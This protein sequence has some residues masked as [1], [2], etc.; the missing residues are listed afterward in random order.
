VSAATAGGNIIIAVRIKP[1]EPGQRDGFEEGRGA[2][3]RDAVD[4]RLR[5]EMTAELGSSTATADAAGGAASS[6]SSSSSRDPSSTSSGRTSTKAFAP[7][8]VFMT[9]AGQAEVY[10]AAAKELVLGVVGGTNAA[11]IAYGQTG[12]GKTHTMLGEWTASAQAGVIPRAIADIFA[13]L[14]ALKRDEGARPGVTGVVA[15][16]RA[17]YVEVYQEQPYD[18]LALSEEAAAAAA[19]GG[20]GARASKPVTEEPRK[21]LRIR[22]DVESD[23]FY[24]EE[25]R[26]VLLTSPEHALEILSAGFGLRRTSSTA[27]NARSS[28][29]HAIL[30]LAVDVKVVARDA[31]GVER[32]T[33]RSGILDIVDLAGSERQRDTGAEGATVKEAGKINNSLGCLAEVIKTTV[34]NQMTKNCR[35]VKPVPWRNSRLTMLLKR[36]LSG[37]SRTAMIFTVSPAVDY[38]AES[39]NTL[40]FADRARRL[41][42]EPSTNERTVLMGGTQVQVSQMAKE[43]A[44][45][46]AALVR[47]TSGD[48]SGAAAAASSSS[49]AAGGFMSSSLDFASSF[50]A[51]GAWEGCVAADG[52]AAGPSASSSSTADAVTRKM[53]FDESAGAGAGAGPASASAGGRFSPLV[54]RRVEELSEVTRLLHAINTRGAAVAAALAA[55]GGAA[56]ATPS[57]DRLAERLASPSVS[58][59]AA[60]V[61]QRLAAVLAATQAGE[62]TKGLVNEAAAVA[63]RLGALA[64]IPGDDF[65]GAKPSTKRSKGERSS[66]VSEGSGTSFEDDAGDYR[67]LP[68]AGSAAAEAS[69]RADEAIPDGMSAS[70]DM[71]DDDEEDEGEENDEAGG[72]QAAASS[73]SSSGPSMAAG[74][75]AAAAAAASRR[76]GGNNPVAAVLDRLQALEAVLAESTRKD[77][78]LAEAKRDMRGL[79]GKHAGVKSALADLAAAFAFLNPKP[80]EGLGGAV[81]TLGAA[82]ALLKAVNGDRRILAAKVADLQGAVRERDNEIAALRAQLVA[83]G[84]RAGGGAAGRHHGAVGRG[85]SVTAPAVAAAEAAMAPAAAAPPEFGSQIAP[86][87]EV[88]EADA[89]MGTFGMGM[90]LADPDAIAASAA[91]AAA[92]HADVHHPPV[93]LPRANRLIRAPHAAPTPHKPDAVMMAAAAAA[94]SAPVHDDVGGVDDEEEAG[95]GMGGPA[96]EEAAPHEPTRLT[97]GNLVAGTARV[98]DAGVGSFLRPFA[99]GA[100]EVYAQDKP[101]VSSAK[102]LEILAAR[103]RASTASA[104]AFSTTASRNTSVGGA[105]ED[106][107]RGMLLM[108]M[109]GD[110]G[111]PEQRQSCGRDEGDDVGRE[112]FGAP[113]R[114]SCSPSAQGGSSSARPSAVSVAESTSS[115]GTSISGRIQVAEA[116]VALARTLGGLGATGAAAVPAAA[117]AAAVVPAPV[118]AA[119]PAAAAPVNKKPLA[120]LIQKAAG[121]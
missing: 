66:D 7:E 79:A 105:G 96:F 77:A 83:G 33:S 35:Y 90:G 39:L 15:E 31:G 75:A 112:S 3:T 115:I 113:D 8:H 53:D 5:I 47:A 72:A 51:M 2:V 103:Q 23:G 25:V 17:S 86:T 84:A 61:A 52:N 20:K 16:V 80:A 28:R 68:L 36:S 99:R 91:A 116:A 121:K 106:E 64:S 40:L 111:Y 38:W 104:S 56:G 55:E 43:I 110:G 101:R 81:T 97:V 119:V 63:A 11:I 65:A 57:S 45:L 1:A 102:P 44:T 26:R 4:G 6:S 22:E 13:R 48:G 34:D 67:A 70:T 42:T 71:A 29:S 62:E 107:Y 30:S 114:I 82:A 14:E 12:S 109:D 9:D 41:K 27:M 95:A 94:A 46:R 120:F 98:N 100:S 10:E 89:G 32:S 85:A 54:A 50:A 49:T 117:A 24:L 73:S 92:A 74:A 18:L 59:A 78:L 19:G 93:V 37:N 87:Q 108:G 58:G 88:A 69:L 21:L 60:G 76:G 118:A